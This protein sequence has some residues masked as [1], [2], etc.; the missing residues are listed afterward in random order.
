M[1]GEADD[2]SCKQVDLRLAKGDN[3]QHVKGG[4]IQEEKRER[5]QKDDSSVDP[6]NSLQIPKNY[7]V[8][9]VVRKVDE[10]QRRQAKT[11]QDKEKTVQTRSQPRFSPGAQVG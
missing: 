3:L 7:A 6:G 8:V 9:A 11:D 10:Q 2:P 4:R 1:A 5:R